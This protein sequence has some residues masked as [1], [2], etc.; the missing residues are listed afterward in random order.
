MPNRNMQIIV[1]KMLQ[2]LI[3]LVANEKRLIRHDR[4][5]NVFCMGE[6]I[7]ISASLANSYCLAQAYPHH[8]LIPLPSFLV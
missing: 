1:V 7:P 3:P 8:Y 2:H 4:L 6:G 5:K